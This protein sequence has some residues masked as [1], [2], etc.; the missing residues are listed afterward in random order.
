MLQ[1]HAQVRGRVS[2]VR[3]PP[4]KIAIRSLRLLTPRAPRRDR[5]RTC[6]VLLRVPGKPHANTPIVVRGRGVGTGGRAQERIVA[7]RTPAQCK[8]F[9]RRAA[10]ILPPVGWIIR[11]R[12]VNTARPFPDIAR[13]IQRTV[14]ADTSR[15]LADWRSFAEIRFAAIGMVV[16]PGVAPR[17]DP[18][19]AATG[20][21]LPFGLGR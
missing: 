1:D 9:L 8:V 20:S 19:I 6:H 2:G 11:I 10:H 18:P 5:C 15:V 13:H 3:R 14:G 21:F 17:V 4:Q 16:L 7:P 12:C